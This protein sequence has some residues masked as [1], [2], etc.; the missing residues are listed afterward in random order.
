MRIIKVQL[1]CSCITPPRSIYK[2]LKENPIAQM[3]VYHNDKLSMIYHTG[4]CMPP[5]I[6]LQ[7]MRDDRSFGEVTNSFQV[8]LKDDL[9]DVEVL[10]SDAHAHELWQTPN[11]S[12]C[13]KEHYLQS[14]VSVDTVSS[15]AILSA[16][17]KKRPEIPPKLVLGLIKES[18]KGDHS[19]QTTGSTMTATRTLFKKAESSSTDSDD[20]LFCDSPESGNNWNVDLTPRSNVTLKM[21]EHH[22][23]TGT[24]RVHRV[25][26]SMKGAIT[27]KPIVIFH[28]TQ[29]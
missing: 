3:V 28:I 14:T 5:W 16:L 13:G 10:C 20:V 18:T 11:K 25:T 7:V 19:L 4:D 27:L 22:E 29:V 21:V 9:S 15:D 26:H 6:N 23:V 2:V 8:Q 1:D 12:S 24:E 17:W